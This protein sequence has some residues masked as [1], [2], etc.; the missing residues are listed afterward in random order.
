MF[1]WSDLKYFLAVAKAGSTLAAAKSIGVNQSTVHRR[2]QELEKRLGCQ[3]VKRHPTGYR[4]TEFG[5]E[6]LGYAESVEDA[7]VAFERHVSASSKEPRGTV[8]VTCPAAVGARLMRSRLIEKLRTRHPALRV[9]F[10]MSDMT[11]DLAKGEADIAIRAKTPTDNALF[12]RKIAD[13]QWAVYASHLYV[14]RH[15]SV[16]RAADINDHAVVMFSGELRDH[17][18]VRW[19]KSVAPKATV[20][21][22]GSNLTALLM[23][24]KSAA[25]LAPMPLIVGEYEKDLVRVF[26]PVPQMATPFYLLMHQDMRQTPRVRA[27]FDFVIE[28]LSVIRP[29][30]NCEPEPFPTRKRPS[31][32]KSADGRNITSRKQGRR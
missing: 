18:S 31:G 32:R 27:V 25:G 15:G 2:L 29:L 20:A 5:E 3:L 6:M 10:A 24:A 16:R 19:L 28:H 4:L 8:K 7:A 22:H 26:G 1:D 11:L 23:A 12:G 17:Q 30:L 9:E 14:A 21:A 13:S